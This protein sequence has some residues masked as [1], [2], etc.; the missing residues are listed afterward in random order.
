MVNKA[1]TSSE[2]YDAEKD[3][4]L[5]REEPEFK[6]ENKE[7]IF[8]AGQSRRVWNELYK[9]GMLR[10]NRGPSWSYGSSNYNYLCNK[11]LSLLKLWGW[12]PLMAWHGMLDATLCDK[13]CQWLAAE[14]SPRNENLNLLVRIKF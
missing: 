13:V 14:C 8:R 12:I 4:D 1:S 11:C 2:S 5:V 3:Q 6:D 9:V 10:E 7:V